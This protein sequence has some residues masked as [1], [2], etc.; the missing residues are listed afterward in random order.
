VAAS[1]G[2]ATFATSPAHAIERQHHLGLG[3]ELAMLSVNHKSTASVGGGGAIHY[4]YG[5]SDQWNLAVEASSAIVA[6]DQGQDF[7]DSPR[8]R[9]A[10]VDH[11]AVGVSYVIDI[12]RWVP[13]IGVQ[14][15]A[16]RLAGGTLPDP[17]FLPGLSAGAGLDYQI[18]RSFAVGVGV[19]QH[20]MVSKLDTYPSYTTFV[21]RLE[22]MWGY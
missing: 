22:Y 10:T 4:T 16:Y 17:L 11:A 18:S 5:M 6:L 2:A 20:V 19:R 13:Y 1:V 9:P 8:N 7:P 15:G 21:L 14:G 12:L 3:P